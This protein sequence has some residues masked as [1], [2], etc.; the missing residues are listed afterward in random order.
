M[1][2]DPKPNTE[3]VMW[4]TS[5][6]SV[7]R[8]LLHCPMARFIEYFAGPYG[9]GF[10]RKAQSI[11]LTTGQYTHL[12][13]T[14]TA[15]W[16]MEYRQRVGVQPDRAPDEV[17]RWAADLAV[18]DYRRV[19][20]ESGLLAI[21]GEDPAAQ[22]ELLRTINEQAYLIE[23]L[24]WT[25]SLYRLPEILAE[26]LVVAVEEEEEY[27]VAC[28]CGLGD[29]LGGFRE[30]ATR[31]C[32][33]IGL[34]SRPDFLLER[35]I[36]HAY[37]Y[38]ELKT[39]SVAWKSWAEGFERNLQ[40]LMGVLG[41]EKRH[42]VEVTH[43]RVEGLI[44][45][46]RKRDYPYEDSQPK[47]QQSPL[48][49]AYYEPPNPPLTVGDWLPASSYV[50]REGIRHSVPRGRDS[51]YK[52]VGLW[53]VPDDAF[54]N[55][56]PVMSRS[57]YIV[58][59]WAENYPHHLQQCLAQVGPIPKKRHQLDQALRSL[60]TVEK[61]WQERLWAIYQWQV[62][63]GGKAWGSD[64]YHQFVETVI[65]RSYRCLPFDGHPCPNIPVCFD[66][67]TGWRDPIGSGQWLFR[68]PHHV[69]EANMVKSRGWTPVP[70]VTAEDEAD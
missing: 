25:W 14:E 4:L 45:G 68:H 31:T 20:T 13:C 28:T 57:E 12:G 40:L 34:Q 65:P 36:D 21:T 69:A 33:G 70:G 49:F 29:G 37:A 41:A 8:D 39:A 59:Y 46:Q 22:A 67:E 51:R 42:G 10:V 6:S 52:R 66:E 23:G 58:R 30:H 48:C 2:T 43:C 26:Y 64:E 15:R 60:V 55:K 3:P 16:I 50:D 9:A 18:E 11:P 54:P 27:V 24:V 44:K 53:D 1:S 63:H 61:S 38:V 5:R 32:G 47:T 35:R 62:E 7:E 56:P 17:I 19:I